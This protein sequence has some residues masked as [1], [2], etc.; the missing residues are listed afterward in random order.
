LY[1]TNIDQ[2]LQEAKANK[3]LLFGRLG[4]QSLNSTLPPSRIQT[5]SQDPICLKQE[6][7]GKRAFAVV[8]RFWDVSTGLDY[9]YKEPCNKKKFNRK[10]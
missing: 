8:R 1:N 4:I 6:T 10:I 9:I 5:P 3:E 2:F 7:L